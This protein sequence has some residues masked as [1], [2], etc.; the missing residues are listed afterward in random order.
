MQKTSDY[1]R[2]GQP[3]PWVNQTSHWKKKIR[4]TYVKTITQ[5][6]IKDLFNK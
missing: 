3:S 4:N 5:K 2:P 1:L 6:S